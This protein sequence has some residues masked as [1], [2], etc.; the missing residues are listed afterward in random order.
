M[1]RTGNGE[2]TDSGGQD[3]RQKSR[4]EFLKAGAAAAAGL[5]FV[6]CSVF[7]TKIDP[8]LKVAAVGQ[9]ARIPVTAQPW[10]ASGDGSM[11]IEIEGAEDKILLFRTPKGALAA[12]SMSCTHFGCDVEYSLKAGH[13]VCPCHG[14]EFANDGAVLEGPAKD[15]LKSYPVRRD[16]S[17]IVISLR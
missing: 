13:I 4:R 1:Q 11:A 8:D 16:G 9:E 15:P 14:S 2:T 17:D 5:A 12:V 10:L 6:G 7:A 3:D